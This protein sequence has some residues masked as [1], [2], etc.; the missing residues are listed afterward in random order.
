MGGDKAFWYLFGGIWFAVG[1]SFVLTSLGVDAFADPA[2]MNE[3]GPPQ[4]VFT[5]VGLVMAG[6]GA[7]IIHRT[8]AAAARDKRLMETG[9]TLTATVTDISLSPLK[10]NKQTRWNVCYRYV[11][12]DK[13]HE[14]KS[15]ALPGPQMAEFKSGQTVTIKLDPAKPEES[16]FLGAA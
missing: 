9:L 10:I 1:A 8:R 2:A 5:L 6:A 14:G 3:D 11:F 12:N 7:F 16:L 4:W 15:R 13:T